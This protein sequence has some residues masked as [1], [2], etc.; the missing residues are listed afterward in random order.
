MIR[1][2]AWEGFISFAIKQGNPAT[3]ASN[4][5][6]KYPE[7]DAGL[8]MNA[9]GPQGTKGN[10]FWNKKEDVHII[11]GEGQDGQASIS[12]MWMSKDGKLGINGKEEAWLT[13][14]KG[15]HANPEGKPGLSIK[16]DKTSIGTEKGWIDMDDKIT[17]QGAYAN[18]NNQINIYA[19]FA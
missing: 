17:F 3:N 9:G 6:G 11:Q 5:D 12:E 13:V 16:K 18:E 4:L 10:W 14:G 15:A 1:G 2:F 8:T 7:H 19:R